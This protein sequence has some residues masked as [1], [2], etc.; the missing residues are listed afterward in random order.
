MP[1]ENQQNEGVEWRKYVPLVLL[2]AVVFAVSFWYFSQPTLTEYTVSGVKVTSEIPLADAQKWVYMALY[3][4]EG[5]AETTCNFELASISTPA[6]N[7]VRVHV[8]RGEPGLYLKKNEAYVRGTSDY[9]LLSACH[10]LACLRD[11][12]ICPEDF[13][14]LSMTAN[15]MSEYNVVLDENLSGV[16]ARGFPEL[17]GVLGYVQAQRVDYDADGVLEASEINRT[18]LYIKP[19]LRVN[20]SCVAQPLTNKV[21]EWRPDNV[22]VPCNMSNAI[23]LLGSG[24]NRISFTDSTI[25]VEGSGQ[26]LYTAAI[27][28]RDVIS[29]NW[30]R[31]YYQLD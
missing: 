5:K 21:Q 10:V 1:E 20:D 29:P 13:S 22:T 16:G 17:L 9:E 24:V 7:G 28:L 25:T 30:I 15:V 3:T 27:V 31:K 12:I 19:Y 18:R 2:L 23:Y 26:A 8:E 4:S 11:N 14:R 6:R